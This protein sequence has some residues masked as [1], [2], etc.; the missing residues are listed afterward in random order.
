MAIEKVKITQLTAAS[1]PLSGDEAL[2]GV[3]TGGSV[4]LPAR[5]FVLPTDSLVTIS[6]MGGSIPGS[7]QLVSS[8]TAIIVDG[9]PG[10]E[11]SIMVTDA[12][13]LPL[14]L[15]TEA[16]PAGTTNDLALDPST[17]FLDIDT[18]AGNV[19]LTGMIAEFDGQIVVVSNSAGGN[20]LTLASLTGSAA[21]NQYRLPID[22]TLTSNDGIAF[23]YSDAIGVWIRL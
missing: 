23:R 9:G 21:D 2:E 6:A 14:G 20:L 10:G 15:Q 4:Q 1:L 22:V 12:Q 18:T 17:G 5:A 19:T 8:P 3:Q 7:R 13:T 16:L 11:V